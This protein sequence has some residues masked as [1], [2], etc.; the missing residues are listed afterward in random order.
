MKMMKAQQAKAFSTWLAWYREYMEQRRKLMLAAGRMRNRK[1]SAAWLTWRDAYEAALEMQARLRQALGRWQNKKMAAG[2]NTWREWYDDM[3]QQKERLERAL[4]PWRNKGLA[5]GWNTWQ[6]YY[7]DI[8]LQEDLLRR[9]VGRWNH[10]ALVRAWNV[11]WEK[12]HPDDDGPR[13]P[14]GWDE[15]LITMPNIKGHNFPLIG[16][17]N[18][19][20]VAAHQQAYN[21]KDAVFKLH[22]RQHDN[23]YMHESRQLRGGGRGGIEE[24]GIPKLQTS[25]NSELPWTAMLGMNTFADTPREAQTTLHNFMLDKDAQNLQEMR[26]A[27]K[28]NER[29]SLLRQQNSFGKWVHDDFNSFDDWLRNG[30]A[31]SA[32]A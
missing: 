5:I 32:E 26:R 3:M 30:G 1:L 2:F 18:A 25:T 28:I 19:D 21:A 9:S 24:N 29:E 7:Y 16:G 6:E 12:T 4:G 10:L 17:S 23:K 11:W 15:D 20:R 22:M 27:R 8:K 13:V 14:E 31:A